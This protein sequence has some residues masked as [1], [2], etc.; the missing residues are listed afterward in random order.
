MAR[1]RRFEAGRARR[2]LS[3]SWAEFMAVLG[4]RRYRQLASVAHRRGWARA[5]AL[6]LWAQRTE[7]V[8]ATRYTLAAAARVALARRLHALRDAAGSRREACSRSRLLARRATSQR[9]LVALRCWRRAHLDGDTTVHLR[10]RA[11]AHALHLARPAACRAALHAWRRVAGASLWGWARSRCA[12]R[13]WH[14]RVAFARRRVLRAWCARAATAAAAAGAPSR[15]E[16]EWARSPAALQA[17]Q[18]RV[19]TVR[20]AALGAWRRASAEAVRRREGARRALSHLV[21]RDLSAGWNSWA[22]RAAGRAASVRLLRQGLSYLVHG[23]LAP[24]FS[25]W[26]ESIA[27]SAARRAAATAEAA[28]CQ[29]QRLAAAASR[30]RAQ[31][32]AAARP[33]AARVRLALALAATPRHALGSALHSWRARN[34]GTARGAARG[35]GVAWGARVRDDAL[36]SRRGGAARAARRGGKRGAAALAQGAHGSSGGAVGLALTAARGLGAHGDPLCTGAL[37]SPGAA[38]VGRAAVAT[39][40]VGAAGGGCD[41][42]RW[43]AAWQVLPAAPPV[44]GLGGGGAPGARGLRMCDGSAP[45]GSSC[46][47]AC[48]VAGVV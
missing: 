46:A 7:A 30:W 10:L 2:A 6:A 27:A 43:R 38:A 23:Q 20:R 36:A 29:R 40:A 11:E 13:A 31:A 25:S 41:G 34:G 19:R 26:R 45:C 15:W 9:A 3:T 24:G 12:L 44:G 1:A 39:G 28:A 21:Y 4:A 5:A 17:W 22:A 33:R 8:A 16:L 35:G 14:A 42:A 37:R 18:Y 32:C 47:A 48:G